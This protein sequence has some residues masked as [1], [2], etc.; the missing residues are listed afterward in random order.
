MDRGRA[1]IDAA[2]R[3]HGL[4]IGAAEALFAA[5]VSGGGRQA[6]FSHPELGGMGQ[7]SSGMV[8]IGDMFNDALKAKVA[9]FCAEMSGLARE[10]ETASAM[11]PGGAM[12]S[13]SE[14][15]LRGRDWWPASLGVPAS[16]GAQNDTRYAFFPDKR[17]LALLE[18][19][20][21]TLYDPGSHRLNGFGQQQGTTGSISFAGQDGPVALDRLTV[22]GE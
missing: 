22:V 10:G 7:W 8:Q 11:P 19:G 3:R 21:V 4:S 13:S 15:S 6:Q 18:N 16:S 20:T 5:L 14:R 12:A 1:D 17:R 2:A 9:G